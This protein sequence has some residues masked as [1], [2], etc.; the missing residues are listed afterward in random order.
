MK[1]KIETIFYMI[2][3]FAILGAVLIRGPLQ[4]M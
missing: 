4:V 2:L 3:P 1:D